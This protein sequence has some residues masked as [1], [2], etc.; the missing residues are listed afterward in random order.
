VGDIEE[1]GADYVREDLSK[2]DEDN[3]QGDKTTS[4]VGW[5]DLR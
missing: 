4:K 2:G 5:A 3:E 1:D